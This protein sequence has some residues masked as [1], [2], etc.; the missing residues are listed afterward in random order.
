MVILYLPESGG[1]YILT[2]V[3]DQDHNKNIEAFK[4][5]AASSRRK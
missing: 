4:K 1:Y 5:L 2:G 3:A